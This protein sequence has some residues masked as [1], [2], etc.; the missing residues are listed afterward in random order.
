MVKKCSDKNVISGDLS[1]PQKVEKSCDID[2]N[3]L[4]ARSSISS[5]ATTLIKRNSSNDSD[6]EL[7]SS[8]S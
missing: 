4:S 5:T 6:T 8:D 2:P 3:S 7:L 1:G